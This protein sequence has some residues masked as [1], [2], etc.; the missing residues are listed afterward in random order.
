LL[1]YV[2]DRTFVT[3]LGLIAFIIIFP[4]H[5]YMAMM[6][7]YMQGWFKTLTKYFILNISF[8]I[9]ALLGGIV[10]SFLAFLL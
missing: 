9:L 5:L 4:I 10:I 1:Q 6:K 8:G 2:F 3:N 7:F